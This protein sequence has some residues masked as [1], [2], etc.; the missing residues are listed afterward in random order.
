MPT[1]ISQNPPDGLPVLSL[2][3]LRTL[4]QINFNF[5]LYGPDMILVLF[6]Q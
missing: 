4:F 5:F 2:I 3:C 1:L 6:L